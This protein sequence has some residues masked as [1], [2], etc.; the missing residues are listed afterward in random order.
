MNLSEKPLIDNAVIT[1]ETPGIGVT[2]ISLLIHSL[3]NILPGSDIAGV[4]ASEISEIILP[5]IK[6]FIISMVFFF[7]L[8]LWNEISCV[9]IL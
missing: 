8:N 6:S 1:D 7:S 5:S 9:F 4:P 3:T 2:G